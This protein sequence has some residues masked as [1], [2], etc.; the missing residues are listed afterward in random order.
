VVQGNPARPVAKVG[1]VLGLETPMKDFSTRL[2]PLG[3]D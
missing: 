2:K 1:I 3:R